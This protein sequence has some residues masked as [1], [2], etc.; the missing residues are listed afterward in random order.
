MDPSVVHE[1]AARC[2]IPNEVSDWVVHVTVDTVTDV[3]VSCACVV[4]VL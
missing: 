1:V 2:A 4:M 3:D